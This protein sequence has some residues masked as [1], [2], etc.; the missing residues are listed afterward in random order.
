MSP[1]DRTRILRAIQSAVPDLREKGRI[2]AATPR[3]RVLRGFYV[4]DSVDS[5][6]VHVWAF[7]QPLYV[8]ATT[9]VLSLGVRLGGQSR[10]WG[11]E[12]TA[13]IAA[14]ARDEGTRFF[15]PIASPDALSTWQ[16]LDH[17][18]D[19]YAREARAFSLLLSGYVD[20]AT[21]CLRQLAGSLV[22]VAPWIR[23]MRERDEGLATLAESD[24]HAA[25]ELVGRWESET[26]AALRLGNVP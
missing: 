22:G 17:R 14:A 13:A 7:V 15:E 4:E 21:Q 3:G 8:P 1:T 12:D 20:E 6:R 24:P 10:A 16:L 5:K 25:I 23:E 19:E 2:L 11:T 26:V 18:P 9:I